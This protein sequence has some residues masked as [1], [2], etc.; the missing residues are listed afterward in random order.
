MQ[1]LSRSRAVQSRSDARRQETQIQ[2]LYDEA[3]LAAILDAQGKV[4]EARSLLERALVTFER[5]HGPDSHQRPA[6]A[7]PQRR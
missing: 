2:P 7:Q 1:K 5:T 4:A 6:P 3:A